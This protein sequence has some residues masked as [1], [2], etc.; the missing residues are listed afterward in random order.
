MSGS[1]RKFSPEFKLQVLSEADAG[2]PVAEICRRYEI[3]SGMFYRWRRNL[4]AAPKNPFPGNGSRSTEKAKMT[5][6]E[7]LIGRQAMEIDFL[8]NALKR[9]KEIER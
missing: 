1:K 8:K 6:M 3:T 4:K 2:V 5:E 7:R 9:L